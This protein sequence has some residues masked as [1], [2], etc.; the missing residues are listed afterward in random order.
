MMDRCARPAMTALA[1]WN[2]MASKG[3]ARKACP[4][5]PEVGAE[6]AIFSGWLALELDAGAAGRDRVD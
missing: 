1:Y 4:A 3:M 6:R 2:L 5:S